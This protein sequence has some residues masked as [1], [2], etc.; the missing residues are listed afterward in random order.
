MKEKKKNKKT[1]NRQNKYKKRGR[2][3]DGAR[4]VK[5]EAHRSKI[6]AII[7]LFPT[8]FLLFL[9]DLSSLGLNILLSIINIARYIVYLG[10]YFK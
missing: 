6:E 1:K 2:R 10:H 9:G 7:K 5:L 4:R 8:V 3:R